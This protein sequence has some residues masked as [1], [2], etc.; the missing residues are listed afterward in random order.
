M[1]ANYSVNSDEKMLSNPHPL[2]PPN[3]EKYASSTGP[4]SIVR[5]SG[6][7]SFVALISQMSVDAGWSCL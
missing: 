5:P 4:T 7:M 1:Y 6:P 3:Y 2:A